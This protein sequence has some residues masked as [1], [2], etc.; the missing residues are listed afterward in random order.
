MSDSF[1]N[2][3]PDSSV[4]GISEARIL[5]WVAVSF[6]RDPPDPRIEPMSPALAGG[7]FTAEPSGK[8]HTG[9][10]L[11]HKMERNWI[12]YRDMDGPRVK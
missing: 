1:V 10:L 8:P 2:S 12:I 7:F 5:E 9:I 6:S 4:L 3:L 11:S